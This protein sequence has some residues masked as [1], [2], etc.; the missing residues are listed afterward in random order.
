MQLK[1]ELNYI[2]LVF[3]RPS[4]YKTIQL[5]QMQL[6]R[7]RNWRGWRGDKLSGPQ[8]LILPTPL[9]ASSPQPSSNYNH[10]PLPCPKQTLK[11]FDRF[12]RSNFDIFL[13]TLVTWVIGAP[14]GAWRVKFPALFIKY[15]QGSYDTPKSTSPNNAPRPPAIKNS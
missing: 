13:N 11:D 4:A 5:W 14:I 15:F 7:C 1:I 12:L 3:F 2:F 6:K 8:P 9:Q 10:I